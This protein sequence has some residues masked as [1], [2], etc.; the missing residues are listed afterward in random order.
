MSECVGNIFQFEY[1]TQA[2]SRIAT[3]TLFF[4]Q[5]CEI[6]W[7]YH[8][9]IRNFTTH[10]SSRVQDTRNMADQDNQDTRTVKS[11]ADVNATDHLDFSD[12]EA[13]GSG[14]SY[15]DPHEIP[16]NV[17]DR[18]RAQAEKV[19]STDPGKTQGK[20]VIK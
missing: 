19:F 6:S 8:I 9:K 13:N 15:L 17:V 18:F 7:P 4:S 12:W 11:D 20:L 3:H 16:C 14:I 5:G 2:R 1:E 10:H